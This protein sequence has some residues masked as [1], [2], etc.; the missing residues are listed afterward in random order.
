MSGGWS[1][2]FTVPAGGT[3]ILLDISYRLLFPAFYE[4]NEYGEA[5]VEI[6][7][8]RLG[9]DTNTSLVHFAGT[10]TD[11]DSGIQTQTFSL[12]LGAGVHTITIGGFNNDATTV[13]EETEVFFDDIRITDPGC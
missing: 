5:L 12:A 2:T 3:T 8:T 4:S 11:Q 13:N 10:S 9:N 7:G 6:D 1:Q